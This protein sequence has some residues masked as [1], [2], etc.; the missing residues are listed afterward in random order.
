MRPG[1]KIRFSA[2]DNTSHCSVGFR[3]TVGGVTGFITAA[4]CERNQQSGR[5]YNAAGQ[6]IGNV[7]SSMDD[8][9]DVAFVQTNSNVVYIPI[10]PQRE[11]PITTFVAS[12]GVGTTLH[13][14]G[15]TSGL[16]QGQITRMNFSTVIQGFRVTNAIE[17]NI[18]SAGGDSGSIVVRS[19][20]SSSLADIVGI[21][22][23]GIPN[24]PVTLI[25]NANHIFQ[26]TAWRPTST[27]PFMPVQ[28]S[29]L[30]ML[31]TLVTMF[32]AMD[33]QSAALTLRVVIRDLE[34]TFSGLNR[35]P[36]RMLENLE[37]MES[38]NAFS[39]NQNLEN[40]V[41]VFMLDSIRLG[42]MI[43]PGFDFDIW[44][45]QFN[46]IVAVYDF[47]TLHG[48]CPSPTQQN[49]WIL[50]GLGNACRL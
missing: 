34:R 49:R 36:L 8:H 19:Q 11:W 16:R 44:V 7:R 15:A 24:Q 43:R 42:D 22:I 9:L 13:T 10:F 4:H 47:V 12:F 27:T 18:T 20:G 29:I 45:N 17:S 21:V 25:S 5:V 28:H 30:T 2:P 39:N 31:E 50:D 1:D 37:T 14:Y 35:A 40:A 33:N 23:A 38:V 46:Q 32:R 48:R 3:A 26:N 6:H 41:L